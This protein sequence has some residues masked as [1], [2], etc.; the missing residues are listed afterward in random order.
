MRNVSSNTIKQVQQ[1]PSSSHSRPSSS[2][3]RS[4]H[5]VIEPEAG[6][7]YVKSKLSDRSLPATYQPKSSPTPSKLK[8]PPPS[9]SEDAVSSSSSDSSSSDAAMPPSRSRLI[10]QRR[11]RYSAGA[12][13][14]KHALSAVDSESD[15]EAPSFLPFSRPKAGRQGSNTDKRPS[16]PSATLRLDTQMEEQ[17][18][19]DRQVRKASAA[20]V[21]VAEPAPSTG[22]SSPPSSSS[23]SLQSVLSSP[24]NTQP[25][26]HLRNASTGK[27]SRATKATPKTQQQQY[28]Q[29]AQSSNQSSQKSSSPAPALLSPGSHRRNLLGRREPSEV[30]SPSMGSSFSDLDDASLTRSALEEALVNQMGNGGSALS[31][32]GMGM[33]LGNVGGGSS[34]RDVGSRIREVGRA[35]LKRGTG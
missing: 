26:N 10:T 20:S 29:E 31:S 13:K 3:G 5:T 15:D 28:S 12:S 32:L 21:K 18:R 34:V 8:S 35:A 11:P 19:N 33:G 6:R 17:S 7:R 27:P 24:T 2:G 30:G 9:S 16:D 23:H 22:Q 1:R 14:Q 4:T 25:P